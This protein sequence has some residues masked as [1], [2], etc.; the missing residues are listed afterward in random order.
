MQG[1]A[2]PSRWAGRSLGPSFASDGRWRW[3]LPYSEPLSNRAQSGSM[4]ALSLLLDATASE[5]L[6]EP[7][8][9]LA[10]IPESTGFVASRGV[11]HCWEV[12]EAAYLSFPDVFFHGSF[13]ISLE[14]AFV[15]QSCSLIRNSGAM[16]PDRETARV[17]FSPKNS[18]RI[19][20][21][22]SSP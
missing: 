8:V 10:S 13:A 5:S 4:N 9:V 18:F 20:C 21:P 2:K 19:T 17:F 7:F 1:P 22:I 15:R 16:F 11:F 6:R 14:E 3:L 12:A